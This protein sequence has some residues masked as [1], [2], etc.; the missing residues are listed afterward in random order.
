MKILNFKKK[1]FL[2]EK[3]SLLDENVFLKKKVEKLTPI[4]DRFTL[5]SEN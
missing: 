2:E 4:I 1:K 5:S 3:K